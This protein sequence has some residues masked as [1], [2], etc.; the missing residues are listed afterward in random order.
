MNMPHLC[1]VYVWPFL[2]LHSILMYYICKSVDSSLS[3]IYVPQYVVVF[4]TIYVQVS[5]FLHQSYVIQ[6]VVYHYVSNY[7]T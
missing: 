4:Y 7:V 5:G 6:Y 3:R 1:S 2:L